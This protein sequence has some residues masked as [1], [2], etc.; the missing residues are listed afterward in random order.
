M[1]LSQTSTAFHRWLRLHDGMSGFRAVLR[2]AR[3][4]RQRAALDCL[5]ALHALIVWRRFGMARRA[6]EQLAQRGVTGETR[7]AMSAWMRRHDSEA[8]AAALM[9]G[10]M[11]W[12][13]LVGGRHHEWHLQ[14]LELA[15][16]VGLPVERKQ[17]RLDGGGERR[18]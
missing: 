5:L 7:L 9:S 6:A 10:A 17:P 16:E 13:G 8:A 1:W 2:R 11:Q 15:L 14:L 18:W 3:R 12:R 4:R